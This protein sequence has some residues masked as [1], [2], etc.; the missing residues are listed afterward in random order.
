MFTHAKNEAFFGRVADT[1]YFP[2]DIFLFGF[3]ILALACQSWRDFL[4]AVRYGLDRIL[5]FR[6]HPQFFRLYFADSVIVGRLCLLESQAQHFSFHSA[7]FCR[8]FFR[9]FGRCFH[10][11]AWHHYRRLCPCVALVCFHIRQKTPLADNSPQKRVLPPL[12]FQVSL[13][14]PSQEALP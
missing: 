14:D 3:K 4:G 2:H 1:Q 8:A 12:S 10:G 5:D 6:P 9:A 7:R 13:P 11:C